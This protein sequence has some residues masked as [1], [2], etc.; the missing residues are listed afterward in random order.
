MDPSPT[1]FYRVVQKVSDV[2]PVHHH[3]HHHH[4]HILLYQRKESFRDYEPSTVS[5]FLSVVKCGRVL[6]EQTYAHSGIK[7]SRMAKGFLQ[8]GEKNSNF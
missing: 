2:I 3:H 6:R 7:P 4:H 5:V 8:G 1:G